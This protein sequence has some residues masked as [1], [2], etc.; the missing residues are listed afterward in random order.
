MTE[1]TITAIT[2][3][4]PGKAFRFRQ[5]SVLPGF[6]AEH[7]RL[8]YRGVAQRRLR[9][10]LRLDTGTLALRGDPLQRP[11]DGQVR[12]DLGCLRPYPRKNQ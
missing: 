7:R 11:D 5:H 2:E 1:A 12:R 4:L 8:A 3:T 6:Q 10:D 9:T